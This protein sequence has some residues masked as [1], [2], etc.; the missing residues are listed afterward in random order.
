[1]SKT[2]IDIRDLI[3]EVLLSLRKQPGCAGVR[4]VVIDELDTDDEPYNWAVVAIDSGLS[5]EQESIAG[6]RAIEPE[7]QARYELLPIDRAKG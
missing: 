2:K 5:G 1:M 3:Q 6:L 7:L 4:N